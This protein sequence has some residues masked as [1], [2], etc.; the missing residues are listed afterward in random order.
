M[1][2][3]NRT[4]GRIEREV[5]HGERGYERD[6]GI[7]KNTARF[8]KENNF[9]HKQQ[10]SSLF[11]ISLL[12]DEEKR[13]WSDETC[14][15]SC[16]LCTDSYNIFRESCLVFKRYHVIRG[17]RSTSRLSRDVVGNYFECNDAY[18][19]LFRSEISRFLFYHSSIRFSVTVEGT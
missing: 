12:K 3:S 13:H 6:N 14:R 4:G 15:G 19:G 18:E 2:E 9:I 1:D 7:H 10:L 11:Y 17:M 8:H 5:E 16:L